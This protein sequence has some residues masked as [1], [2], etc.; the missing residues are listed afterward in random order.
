IRAVYLAPKE[1]FDGMNIT[2]LTGVM[3]QYNSFSL[4]GF[5]PTNMTGFDNPWEDFSGNRTL[6]KKREMLDAYIHRSWFYAP[7]VRPHFVLTSEEL[8]TIF[9]FPGRVS[10]TPSLGRIE[11][12]KSEP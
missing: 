4:N 2:G 10:E 5:K 6:R 7:Y 1:N 12:L 9:H 8:A 11:S 3:K